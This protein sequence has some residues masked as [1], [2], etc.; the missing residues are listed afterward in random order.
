[1]LLLS[2][3]TF[4]FR[5]FI[6][7]IFSQEILTLK[8]KI[9]I[10]DGDKDELNTDLANAEKRYEDLKKESEIRNKKFESL[11]D[12][13]DLEI[14][15]LKNKIRDIS[16]TL[17]EKSVEDVENQFRDLQKKTSL[18]IRDLENSVT[19][20][21]KESEM[22]RKK[23]ADICEEKETLETQMRSD[24]CD[25]ETIAE[26]GQLVDLL[27]LEIQDIKDNVNGG[28]SM[29]HSGTPS[30]GTMTIRE[31]QEFK[32]EKQRLESKILRLTIEKMQLKKK[33]YDL[34]K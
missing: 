29:R 27:R 21:D 26:I 8:Q 16:N 18:R 32:S 11:L 22:L 12:A 20:K 6:P 33:I 5:S 24:A 15:Q 13:R 31:N 25:D 1:M 23:I 34:S 4:S 19:V 7:N 30:I 14:Q 2:C 10:Q 3:G 17:F 9:T 28:I